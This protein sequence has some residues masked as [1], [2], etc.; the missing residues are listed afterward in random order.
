MAKEIRYTTAVDT[1]GNLIHVNDA[2]K[3]TEYFCPE[4]KEKLILKK[5][6][7]SG[8]GSRR[9]HFTHYELTHNCTPEGVLHIS[10]KRMLVEHL[11]K[12]ITE[13]IKIPITWTCETCAHKNTG[14]LLEKVASV[15]EE[16]QLGVCRPDIALLDKNGQIIAVIEI[17]VTHQ[18]EENALQYY[19]DNRIALIQINLTSEEELLRIPARIQKPDLVDYCMNSR[20]TNNSRYNIQRYVANQPILCARCLVTRIERYFVKLDGIF[21]AGE[22]RDF[23]D[24][25]ID[26]VKSKRTNIQVTTDPKTKEKYPR[27]NCPVCG[28]NG[29]GYR[30]RIF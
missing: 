10:F 5:S 18:P 16:Y 11:E 22:S 3:G 29:R 19:Q 6:G 23:T 7:K 28:V 21:G 24:S 30:S 17:V 1:D 20:C 26:F 8:P 27:F 9:P 12:C 13:Y 4:C 25:E 2:E 14:N 15:R